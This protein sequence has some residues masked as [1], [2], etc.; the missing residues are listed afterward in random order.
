MLTVRKLIEHLEALALPDSPVFFD[1][2]GGAPLL[3]VGG[4]AQSHAQAA[5]G[6]IVSLAPVSLEQEGGF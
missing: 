3:I 5:G 1:P 2:I 4:I 6:M